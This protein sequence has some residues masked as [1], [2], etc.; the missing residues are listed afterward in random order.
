MEGEL[1]QLNCKWL[2]WCSLLFSLQY[3]DPYVLR[4]P[5]LNMKTQ[6]MKR[7]EEGN[8]RFIKRK[9]KPL[10]SVSHE[11]FTFV[12]LP[13][14]ADP[15][16]IHM[17]TPVEPTKVLIDR[18]K[19]GYTKYLDPSATTYNLS[20]VQ[21]S[22]QELKSSVAAHD[23]ITIWNWAQRR[24]ETPT[25]TTRVADEHICDESNAHD[26]PRRRLEY[27]NQVKRVP[28]TGL[29][30]E[31][32]AN[33]VDPKLNKE[34]ID[35]NTTDVRPILISESVPPFAQLSEYNVYGSGDPVQKY[36]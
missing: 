2:S 16:P 26:C 19:S 30:T 17:P 11:A 10:M 20:Y 28:H 4:N 6:Y 12:E 35:Y 25:H 14:E 9:I 24:D 36:V 7:F 15:L 18:S 13:F 34:Y 1:L 33:Y 3:P 27:R 29:I 22:P 8:L 31:V 32:R 23:N 5:S 21:Y